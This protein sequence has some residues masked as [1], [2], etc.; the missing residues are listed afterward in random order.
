[1]L[2]KFRLHFYTFACP[3]NNWT[4]T[5]RQGITYSSYTIWTLQSPSQCFIEDNFKVHQC[6]VAHKQ[7]CCV[8][9][10]VWWCMCMFILVPGYAVQSLS[11][12][13]TQLSDH[14]LVMWAFWCAGLWWWDVQY[15]HS[16]VN[17]VRLCHQPRLSPRPLLQE[18]SHDP[19]AAATV[20]GGCCWRAM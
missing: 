7:C 6:S 5:K 3:D 15:R 13:T 12:D 16:T 14:C 17:K 10:G 18:S 8:L 20:T 11:T 2:W 19:Q 4:K 9:T 1:M